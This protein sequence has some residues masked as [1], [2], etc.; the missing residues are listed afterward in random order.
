MKEIGLI[1]SVATGHTAGRKRWEEG[2]RSSRLKRQYEERQG[3]YVCDENNK[4]Q[5]WSQRGH[6]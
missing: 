4:T 6:L 2:V 3:K 1:W 5:V